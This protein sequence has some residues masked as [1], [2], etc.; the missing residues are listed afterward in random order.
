MSH[1]TTLLKLDNAAF[2]GDDLGGALAYVLRDMA[3]RIEEQS[4]AYLAGNGSR[5]R[6]R[7]SNGNTVGFLTLVID[8][9]ED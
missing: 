8:D 2:A 5:I 6:A 3:S 1:A 4:R 7:D 9:E